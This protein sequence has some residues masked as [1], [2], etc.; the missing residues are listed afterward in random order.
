M[1]AATRSGDAARLALCDHPAM[2]HEL[3]ATFSTALA[4]A[5]DAAG[6]SV[7]QVR[8]RRRPA[9]GVVYA[10]D[11]VVTT[12]RALGRE[13]DLHVCAADGQERDAELAGWD[14]ASGLAVLRVPGLPARAFVPAA[15]EARVGHVALAVARS[16]SNAVT[17]TAGL[18]SVIGGPL[19]TGRRRAIDRVI[20]TSAPMHDGF[21]GGAFIDT[22]GA[23]LG[24][25]TAATIR[26]LGVVIPVGI[27][28][29]TVATV[30][31][32]GSARRGYIG[33]AA[34]PVAL[35]EPQRGAAGHD[36]GLLVAAVAGR[37][38][39][40][41][42]GVVVGDVIVEFESHPIQDPEE[43]L[44]WLAG[45][46]IGRSIALRVLRGLQMI[47]IEV[48]VGERPRP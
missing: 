27:A 31:E 43:L 19:P 12:G 11:V 2:S 30:L 33:V 7:V 16:W 42:A 10:P 39:A 24:V 41:A 21:A 15:R 34:Q 40:A 18:V 48:A 47:D 1:E 3:L 13:N 46:R 44:D 25:A 20:R 32:H 28:W 23:L 8:G 37:G 45:E 17:A 4:E 26:G 38:P 14:P 5:V 9:S 29:K 6:P 36:R 22:S 35:S